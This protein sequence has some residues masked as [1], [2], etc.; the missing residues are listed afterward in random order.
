MTLLSACATNPINTC[1]EPTVISKEIQ[2]QAADELIQLRADS[3]LVEVLKA[4]LND[5]DKLRACRSI[6]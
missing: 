6:R 4:S 1:P 3:A 2:E 5:R